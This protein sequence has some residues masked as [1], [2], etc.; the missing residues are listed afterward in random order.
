MNWDSVLN[1]LTQAPGVSGFERTAAVAAAELF[2]QF[3][4]T[5]ITVSQSLIATLRSP[6]PKDAPLLVFDAH[7]DEIGL[8][9]TDVDENGFLTF[10]C[11]GGIIPRHLPATEVCVHG[12][13]DVYGVITSTPPHLAKPGSTQDV[14]DLRIDTG[15]TRDEL[16]DRV[17]PGDPVT[18]IGTTQHLANENRIVSRALDDRGCCAILLR[19]AE[20]LHENPP[21]CRVAFT[22]TSCEEINGFGAKTTA[23]SLGADKAIVIDVT[24]AKENMSAA[25]NNVHLGDGACIDVAPILDREIVATLKRLAK[26]KEIP[27]CTEVSTSRTGTNSEDFAI[28]GEGCPVGLISLPL[29]YMHTPSE[30]GDVR[31]MEACAQLSA[32]F[33]HTL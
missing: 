12:T 9:V 32:A 33:A 2:E 7:L 10:S 3:C 13:E 26:E 1:T 5:E 21:A 6:A 29:R 28:C 24:H 25:P 14:P 16:N 31:D 8:I 23:F 27:W 18:F 20:L 15:M 4:D 11:V 17:R 30:V 22:L 19:I